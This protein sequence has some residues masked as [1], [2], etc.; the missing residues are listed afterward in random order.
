MDP[1]AVLSAL[2]D[3][4]G[5]LPPTYLVGCR[6]GQLTEGI[7]LTTAVQDAVP[8]AEEAVHRLVQQLIDDPQSVGKRV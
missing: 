1:V 2:P 3:L 6:P 7:G 8:A 5:Q 4:G